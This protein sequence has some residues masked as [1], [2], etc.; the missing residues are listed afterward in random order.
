MAS[1]IGHILRKNC[2][3]EDVSEGEVEGRIEVTKRRGRSCQ[4]LL[5]DFKE[6]QRYWKLKEKAVDLAL[7]RTGFGRIFKTSQ[8]TEC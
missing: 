2:L 7:W 8:Y 6:K 3:L 5:V 4:Q 1:W